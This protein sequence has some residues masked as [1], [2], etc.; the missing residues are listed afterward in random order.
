MYP[1]ER[2]LPGQVCYPAVFVDSEDV[3]FVEIICIVLVI[4]RN[5]EQAAVGK[6]LYDNLLRGAWI[7][8]A[9]EFHFGGHVTA[10]VVAGQFSD[11]VKHGPAENGVATYEEKVKRAAGNITTDLHRCSRMADDTEGGRW[12]FRGAGGCR[13]WT[14]D[15]GTLDRHRR[16]AS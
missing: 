15:K 14:G 12:G 11:R 6:E 13:L 1:G 7:R 3:G 9:I 16:R 5:A 10:R 2:H 4:G 8:A